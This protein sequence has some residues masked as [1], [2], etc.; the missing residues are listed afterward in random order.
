MSKYIEPEA[1][2]K[3]A[4]STDYARPVL[5]AMHVTERETEATDG[6]RLHRVRGTGKLAAGLW[7]AKSGTAC[8]GQYPNIDRVIP[9]GAPTHTVEDVAELRAIVAAAVAYGKARGVPSHITFRLDGGEYIALNASYLADVLRG[10]GKYEST[11]EMR[12]SKPLGPVRID[13]A[14]GLAV[15]MPF[16]TGDSSVGSRRFDA[17]ECMVPYRDRRA[18]A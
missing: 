9:A 14:I 3:L 6:H 16:R 13:L 15:L 8:D 18:A 1:W 12:A 11:I 5:C 4:A 7:D 10:V 2:V 17:T